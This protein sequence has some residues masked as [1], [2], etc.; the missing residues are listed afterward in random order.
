MNKVI[1]EYDER[2]N[3]IHYKSA[4]KFEFWKEY[5][6]RDNLIHYNSSTGFEYWIKYDENN[7]EIHCKNSSGNE[8]WHKYDKNGKRISITHQEFK[9][10]E[11]N[12]VRKELYLNNKKSNRFELMDI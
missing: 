11:R 6:D 1:N 10:I 3:L 8:S 9:Q 5:D 7:N 2:N 12:K 4:S